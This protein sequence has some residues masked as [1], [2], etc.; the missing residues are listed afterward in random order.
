MIVNLFYTVLEISATVSAVILF[1]FLLMPFL[2]KYFTAKWRYWIWLILVI[3]LLIPINYHV[4]QPVVQIQM[5]QESAV[6]QTVPYSVQSVQQTQP[7][8]SQQSLSV[9]KLLAIIWTV[10]M[11]LLFAYR[12]SAYFV[13]LHR[14][15][16]WSRPVDDADTL[17]I[18]KSVKSELAI[19]HKIVF[20]RSKKIASPMMTGFFRPVLLLPEV[21]YTDE[22]L[23]LILKHELIHLKRR[24]IWYKVLLTLA[25][26]VHWF[27]PIVWFMVY[28]ASGDTELVCDAEVVKGQGDDYRRRY[29]KIILSAIHQSKVNGLVFSTY[30]CGGMKTMKQRI[31]NILDMGKKHRGIVAFCVVAVA[32]TAVGAS[33]A[34]G[35][36]AVNQN[37]Q[38]Q[39][40]AKTSSNYV[41]DMDSS[42]DEY[43]QVS[44]SSNGSE[45]FSRYSSSADGFTKSQQ[46]S[47]A[48][49]SIKK[50][51][52]SANTS[53]SVKPQ[54]SSEWV[55]YDTNKDGYK[56]HKKRKDGTGDTVI[57]NDS[58]EAPCLAGEWVYYFPDLSGI[59]KV[60]LDGSQKTRVCTTD[61]FEELN[62][63]T[64]VTA[65]CKNGYILYKLVQLVPVGDSG[66]AKTSYYKLDLNSNKLARV[67]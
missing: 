56:L 50:P 32:V 63:S 44:Q 47:S 34:C 33:V 48:A 26:A 17:E 15:R 40:S 11:I 65:E 37:A 52:S 67:K 12:F 7:V 45:T 1:I 66:P 36:G 22:E 55:V 42:T 57:V 58:V 39:A 35:A 61:A 9:P 5:P 13:F 31:F 23:R 19:W 59:N 38:S 2:K 49:K 30:F 4:P 6:T 21:E 25:N 60:K 27:N 43:S 51:Q 24:D 20:Q 18:L 14:I 29:G 8:Y 3:R 28:K 64:A 16:R 53:Q 46:S 54:N 62:G 10:G 41:Q